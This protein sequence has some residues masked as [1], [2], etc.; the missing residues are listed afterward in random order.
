MTGA[1]DGG[2]GFYREVLGLRA[3]RQE[4]LAADIAN[5]NTP[6]F[7]AVDLDFKEAL[8][9]AMNS[10]T[11]NTPSQ[12]SSALRWQVSDARHFPAP[13]QAAPTGAATSVKYQTDTQVTLDGNSVDLGKTKVAAAANA[14]DYVAAVSFTSQ[15]IRM[16]ATAIGGGSAPSSGG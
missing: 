4:V 7:K 5:A 8:G 15:T 3:Y 2:L 12:Q 9:A 14:V 11:P 16:L 1:I 13:Q 10:G 6:G